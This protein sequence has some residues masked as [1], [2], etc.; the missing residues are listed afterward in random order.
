MESRNDSVTIED[1]LS[2]SSQFRG[3]KVLT[4]SQVKQIDQALAEVGESDEVHLIKNKG[5]L[6]FITKVDGEQAVQD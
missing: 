5:Q 1:T 3:L 2:G 6:R 4:P